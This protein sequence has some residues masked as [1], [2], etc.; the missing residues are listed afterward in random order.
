[1][2]ANTSKDARICS[3]V[4]ADT[5]SHTSKDTEN[6]KIC[7]CSEVNIDQLDPKNNLQT[8][9]LSSP[10]NFAV[11]AVKTKVSELHIGTAIDMSMINI[12]GNLAH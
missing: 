10:K 11:R 4:T 8:F 6:T 3:Q 1:L 12:S 7:V 2:R 9:P 5:E